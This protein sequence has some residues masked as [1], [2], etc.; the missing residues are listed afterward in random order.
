M[1]AILTVKQ[2]KEA[3][4]ETIAAG[5]P[6]SELMRQ[7]ADQSMDILLSEFSTDLVAIFCGPGNNGGDGF[8]LARLL[9]NLMIPV[10][11][12]YPGKLIDG[13]DCNIPSTAP[14]DACAA[15]TFRLSAID[16]TAMS[17][18]AAREYYRLPPDI[19]IYY[20]PDFLESGEA[21]KISCAV[22]AMFGTGLSRPVEG[23]YADCVRALNNSGLPV[24]A[25]DI[26]TGISADTGAVL[27]NA[28]KARKTAVASHYKWGNLLYPGAEYCQELQLL[29]IGVRSA[30]TT[31]Y[32]SEQEDLAALPS[33]PAHS[34][35]S[36]FG[37]ILV[38]GGSAGMSG[39]GYLAAKSAYRAGAGLVELV[40]PECNR[41]IYQTQLPEAVLS[42]YPDEKPDNTMLTGALLRASSVALGMGLSTSPAAEELTGITLSKAPGE[43]PLVVDADALNILAEAPELLSKLAG[44][45][46]KAILTPHPG[47]MARLCKKSIPEILKNPLEIATR[48]AQKYGVIVVLKDSRTIITD[49]KTI[50]LNN[51]ENSGLATAGS[52]DVLAGIIAA[53]SAVCKN[54]FDA[55]R[56]GVLAHAAAGARAAKIFGERGMMAS[57]IIEAL[58]KVLK[59]AKADCNFFK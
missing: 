9:F 36:T 25:I 57:D 6:S 39:A 8:L 31:C 43:V 33:R 16:T 55:A 20:T 52:G 49:G 54:S 32:L 21:G 12:C 40:A 30:D 10:V 41:I 26:P 34:N 17:K 15:S 24:L 18:D 47:E 3:E 53:F 7:V 5:T 1:K 27:G 23:R 37:R 19:P 50:F 44:R 11:V 22:D 51:A 56:L 48:F 38:V 28:V 14:R 59:P 29:D 13:A 46:R 42:V 35:K 4:R 2:M 58:C 45:T